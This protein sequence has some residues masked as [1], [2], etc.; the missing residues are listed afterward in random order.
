MN[1]KLNAFYDLARKINRKFSVIPL[2]YGSLG[3]QTMV[4]EDIAPEDIDL[5]VPQ[6][7]YYADRQW[8]DLLRFMLEDGWTLTDAHE[9]AFCKDGVKVGVGLIDGRREGGIPSVEAFTGID[10]AEIPI[11]QAGSAVFRRLTLEQY[12]VA[13]RHS[14][15]D[16]Y[17]FDHN[18]GKD[19]A[20]IAL[21]ERLLGL[22]DMP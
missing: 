18:N 10:P 20:K 14:V 4:G 1:E 3:L 2:L 6:H 11:V 8:D 5:C 17:R 9:H 19:L 13:Y 21:I 22:R 15:R 12:L 16:S 7:L